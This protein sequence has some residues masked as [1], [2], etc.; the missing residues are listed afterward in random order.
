MQSF[1]CKQIV[2]MCLLLYD[3]PHRFRLC[4]VLRVTVA[5]IEWQTLGIELGIDH[6]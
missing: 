5:V 2:I 6:C 3:E 1:T 4:E